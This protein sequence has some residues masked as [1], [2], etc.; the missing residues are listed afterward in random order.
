MLAEAKTSARAPPAISSLSMPD[1]PNFACT[2]CPARCF[3]CTGDFGQGA[4]QAAGGV[5]Q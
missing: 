4:A 1:G 5:E 2:F 3:E